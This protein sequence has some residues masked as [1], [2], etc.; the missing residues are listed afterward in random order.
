MTG[1]TEEQ[2]HRRDYEAQAKY[3]DVSAA[4]NRLI[5]SPEWDRLNPDEQ[6]HFQS[7]RDLCEGR[8]AAIVRK[9]N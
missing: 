7:T 4:V 2:E 5:L 1:L 9:W 3:R 8:S 6:G